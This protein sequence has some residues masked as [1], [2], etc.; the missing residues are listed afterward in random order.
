MLLTKITVNSQGNIDQRGDRISSHKKSVVQSGNFAWIFS[1]A[2]ALSTAL[3]LTDFLTPS[4]LT[5]KVNIFSSCKGSVFN[6]FFFL[7]IAV[8]ILF[9]N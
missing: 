6:T 8:P 7:L 5:K 2:D 3:T 1:S 4:P 9:I